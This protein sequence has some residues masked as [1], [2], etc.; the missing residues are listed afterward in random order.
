MIGEFDFA[1]NFT[2]DVIEDQNI[3]I[4]SVIITQLFFIFTIFFVSIVISNLIIGLTVQNIT[5]LQRKAGYYRLQKTL[6][7]LRDTENILRT[8]MQKV[9]KEAE[10]SHYYKEK[11]RKFNNVIDKEDILICVKPQKHSLF[12]I[13]FKSNLYYKIYTYDQHTM[14]KGKSLGMEIPDWIVKSRART[15][16][17]QKC[18]MSGVDSL[19]II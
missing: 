15:F 5:L 19:L 6:E 1:D 3:N 17:S 14:K 2:W 16:C 7:Q 13:N 4:F 18:L 11:K 10:L 12:S 9:G 8:M